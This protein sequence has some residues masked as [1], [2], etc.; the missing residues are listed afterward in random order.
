MPLFIYNA[1]LLYIV[2][3]MNYLIW[4]SVP[5]WV[6]RIPAL[7]IEVPSPPTYFTPM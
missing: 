2:V 5:L 4:F 3:S 7:P 1:L 6:K